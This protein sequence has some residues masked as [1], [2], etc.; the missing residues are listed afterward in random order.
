MCARVFRIA[1]LKNQLKIAFTYI[2]RS[3]RI[4]LF[5][6]SRPYCKKSKRIDV[7]T[8]PG[9]QL[10]NYTFVDVLH[11]RVS[12]HLVVI[13]PSLSRRR[14]KSRNYQNQNLYSPSL[15]KQ[16]IYHG[17]KMHTVKSIY[18]SFKYKM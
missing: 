8:H 11:V 1:V 16:G 9:G 10:I 12:R 13:F 14:I 15:H 6:I 18:N 2:T 7:S 5:C 4:S 3:V 17:R